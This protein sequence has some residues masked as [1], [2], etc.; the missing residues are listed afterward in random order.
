[1]LCDKLEQTVV[2]VSH[3]YRRICAT[4]HPVGRVYWHMSAYVNPAGRVISSTKMAIHTAGLDIVKNVQARTPSPLPFHPL[5]F[6]SLRSRPPS[7]QL[8]GLGERCK[9]PQ[10]GLGQSPSRNGIWSILALQYA[11]CWQQIVATRWRILKLK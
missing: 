11:I 10:R 5:P 7:I 3:V 2:S 1:M 9:L 8:Q 4:D 6:P